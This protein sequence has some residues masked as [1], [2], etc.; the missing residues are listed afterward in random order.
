MRGVWLERRKINFKYIY[1]FVVR[2]GVGSVSTV[3]S[4]DGIHA[5]VSG[6]GLVW[7]SSV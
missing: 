1:G 2:S 3:R 6:C 4:C 7:N 5:G